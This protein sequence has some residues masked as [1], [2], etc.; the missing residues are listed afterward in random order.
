MRKE[1]VGTVITVAEPARITITAFDRQIWQMLPRSRGRYPDA[2][3]TLSVAMSF[4]GRE[5][6]RSSLLG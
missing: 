6:E 3:H 5:N 4:V 1:W 2:S